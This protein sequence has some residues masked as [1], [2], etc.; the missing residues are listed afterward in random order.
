MSRRGWVGV[1]LNGT[2][3]RY[4]D[5]QP[6]NHIG[7]PV[8]RMLA[9]VR[10]WL[11]QDIRVRVVTVR[12]CDPVQILKIRQWLDD[13]GLQQ[14]EITDRKDPDCRE[15]WD[16]RC[17]QVI[18]NTGE[19]VSPG[20]SRI[21]DPVA[22]IPDTPVRPQAPVEPAQAPRPVPGVSTWTMG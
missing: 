16:D 18:P 21:P 1:D 11:G 6:Q 9:R 4:D 19:M 5:G 13:L 7:S 22:G 2:L 17:V 20:S 14:V 10:A 8:P 15:M 3:A 12:A